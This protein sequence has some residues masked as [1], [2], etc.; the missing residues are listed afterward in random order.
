MGAKVF[1]MIKPSELSIGNLLNYDTGEG[2][3]LTVIDWQ[4]L[5]W[6]QENPESFNNSHTPVPLTPEI[7][8]GFGFEPGMFNELTLYVGVKALTYSRN[9]IYVDGLIGL[10]DVKNV[11]TLQNFVQAISGVD[12]VF[13]KELINPTQHENN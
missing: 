6:L 11:H 7:L 4:D 12:F 2:I 10:P 8:E 5:R 13:K 3:E 9:S 1:T